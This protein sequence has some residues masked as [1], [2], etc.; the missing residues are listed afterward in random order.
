MKDYCLQIITYYLFVRVRQYKNVIQGKERREW[1]EL[2]LHL[3]LLDGQSWL[4]RTLILRE[5][6][7][8]EKDGNTGAR[9]PT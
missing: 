7:Y 8:I 4:A 2:K 9:G 3:P 5:I 1:R 6:E